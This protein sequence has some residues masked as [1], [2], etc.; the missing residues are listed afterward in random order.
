[1]A[2][3]A[4]RVW[5]GLGFL[6]VF[7]GHLP[8]RASEHAASGGAVVGCQQAG[9]THAGRSIFLGG[10][11]CCWDLAKPEAGTVDPGSAMNL[12]F[13]PPGLADQVRDVIYPSCTCCGLQISLYKG[14]GIFTHVK[15]VLLE[16][17]A[18]DILA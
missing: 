16:Q 3:L 18:F 6:E 4:T 8:S 11:S 10:G 13:F 2:L 9:C 15:E 7:K 1:M 12:H 5:P 17:G 14:V